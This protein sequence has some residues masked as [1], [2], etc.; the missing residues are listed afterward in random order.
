MH[1]RSARMIVGVATGLLLAGSLTGCSTSKSEDSNITSNAAKQAA[2]AG[3]LLYTAAKPVERLSAPLGVFTS[4][5]LSTVGGFFPVQSAMVGVQGQMKLNVSV[6]TDSDDTYRLLE[7]F[8]GAMKT[9]IPDLLNRSGDRPR[10]LN[11]YIDG[12]TNITERSMIRLREI[13]ARLADLKAEQRRLQRENSALEKSIKKQLDAADYAAA[14]EQQKSLSEIQG[15]LS[16]VTTDVKIHDTLESNF[17]SL[18][19][20]SGRRLKAIDENRE[21]LVSGLRAVDIPGVEDLKIIDS[22]TN[23]RSGGG[24]IPIF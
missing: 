12:L 17:E 23:R 2:A 3:M 6:P 8:A 14:A 16:A 18:I 13:S 19:A 21:L 5:Y 11:E 24:G 9:D 15:Q 10:V 22:G 4:V 7:E 20:V 1:Q